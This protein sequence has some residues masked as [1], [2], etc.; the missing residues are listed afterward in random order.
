MISDMSHVKRYHNRTII[1][2]LYAYPGVIQGL[3]HTPSFFFLRT[4]PFFITLGQWRR[5]FEL[6]GVI[7]AR[8][9]ISR[10]ICG[11]EKH[12]ISTLHSAQCGIFQ[13]FSVT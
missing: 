12:E 3:R 9:L 8:N 1:A 7:Q 2:Y 11:V 4:D 5:K 10:K 6:G 13:D